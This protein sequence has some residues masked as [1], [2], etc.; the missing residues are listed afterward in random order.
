MSVALDAGMNE[1]RGRS[2]ELNEKERLRSQP[3]FSNP[4]LIVTGKEDL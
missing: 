4:I 3:S 2:K 1:S